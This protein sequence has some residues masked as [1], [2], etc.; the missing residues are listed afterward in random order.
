MPS[1]KLT[2]IQLRAARK[3]DLDALEALENQS[4][5]YDRLSRKSFLW[6]LTKA[7]ALLHVA[8]ID[9]KVVGY[10]LVLLNTGTRL[11]RL[12]SLAVSK[13]H[14]GLGLGRTILEALM[15]RAE[16]EDFVYLRLEVKTDNYPAI[17]LYEKMG[18]RLLNRK[19][20]YYSDGS[21]ALCF[22]KRI[23][24]LKPSPKFSV[25]YYQQTLEFT[26]GPAC[27]MMSIKKFRPSFKFSIS[28]ELKI[29][30]EATTIFMTSGH[31][32]CGPRGL[33][34][35]AFDRGLR[36][37][38]YLS[39]TGV[40]FEDT[41]RSAEKKN[42]LTVVN[43]T[44]NADLKKR[45]IK[46]NHKNLTLDEIDSILNRGGVVLALITTYH[47]DRRKVPHWVLITAMDES[48]VYFHDPDRS[49]VDKHEAR[50]DRL[51]VP[52]S[53]KQF[54]KMFKFGRQKMMLAL[55]LYKN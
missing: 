47:F 49:E 14:Q 23:K 24:Y 40:L 10:G 33:A 41:V 5:N 3:S 19:K 12:Y 9:K 34:L 38:L 8:V 31:G 13:S 20:E 15:A 22:E 4:F 7:H 45:K 37:V 53:H 54:R 39:H 6:M 51:N 30:R 21:D 36:P 1:P 43:D 32:G 48:F 16:E 2:S 26:C 52:V 46:L 42:V 11:A 27:L 18:F 29:W 50:V 25:P 35:A 28:E 55:A 17:G 44:F